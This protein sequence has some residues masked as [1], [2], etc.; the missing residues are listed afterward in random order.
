MQDPG[1]QKEVSLPQLGQAALDKGFLTSQQL[2]IA[3]GQ[4]DG[5]GEGE[6]GAKALAHHLLEW[7]FLTRDQITELLVPAADRT[8]HCPGCGTEVPFLDPAKVAIGGLSC[9]QCGHV[10]EAPEGLPAFAEAPGP[11]GATQAP[12]ELEKP[13]KSPTKPTTSVSLIGEIVGNCRVIELIGE[14]GMG[15]VYRAYHILLNRDVALKILPRSLDLNPTKIKR[16]LTEAGSLG[17]LASS[18]IVQVF[19]VGEERG[20]H[21]IEMELVDGGSLDELLTEREKL[22]IEE[23]LPVMKSILNGLIAAHGKEII[24]R[25]LKPGNILIASDGQ[26]K[27]ADF[28]LAKSLQKGSHHTREGAMMGTPHHM[29]PAQ[30]RG[31]EV[32]KRSDV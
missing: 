17:S 32:D 22:P 15:L 27:I 11:A 16:F 21:F 2:E 31:K 24:H 30:G 6:N 23:A 13:P 4:F 25:D 26:Y 3:L 1:E 20:N 14:G 5:D 28:G 10:L 7:G 9:P 8:I 19:N 12:G 29:A 18:N